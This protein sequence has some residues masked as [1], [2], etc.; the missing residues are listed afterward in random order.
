MAESSINHC[1]VL[2]HLPSVFCIPRHHFQSLPSNWGEWQSGSKKDERHRAYGTEG[3][4]PHSKANP[5]E[6]MKKGRIKGEERR[7]ERGIGGRS[8]DYHLEDAPL[9]VCFTLHFLPFANS[10]F[11]TFHFCCARDFKPKG[12]IHTLCTRVYCV[13]KI[14]LECRSKTVLQHS[15]AFSWFRRTTRTAS[16]PAQEP[17]TARKGCIKK[18]PIHF[19][20]F[21]LLSNLNTSLQMIG[22][23]CSQWDFQ[24]SNILFLLVF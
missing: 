21:S 2:A 16:M 22:A 24:S 17:T 14:F 9:E 19:S 6:K 12:T 4:W 10:S 1:L 18:W 7:V 15:D 13:H 23:S 3:G 11:L 8:E 20:F 5:A